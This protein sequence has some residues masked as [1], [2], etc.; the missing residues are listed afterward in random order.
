MFQQTIFIGERV[1]ARRRF[2]DCDVRL[3]R[4]MLRTSVASDEGLNA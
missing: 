3:A 1:A 4:N 2:E